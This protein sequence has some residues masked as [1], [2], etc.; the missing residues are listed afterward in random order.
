MKREAV[1]D[2]SLEKTLLSLHAAMDVGSFWKAIQQLLSAAIPNRLIGL[3]LQPNPILPMIA[4]WTLPVPDG[5]FAADP[6][7]SY[8]SAR[9]HHRF[10]RI[11]N[12]FSNRR[13]LMKSAFYR[14]YMAPQRCAHGLCL[15]FWKRQRLICAIAIM[16]TATQDDLSRAE[17][18]LLQQLYPQFQTAL[19]RL[20][21]LERE[22]SVR[23]DLEEF[24]SR[25]PMPTIILRWNLKPIYQNRA[26]REF[27]AIWEKGPEEAKR[28]K[29]AS[30]IPSE[31]LD[32]CRVFKQH[33]AD[34][35]RPNP[36]RA[37]FKEEQVRHPR[38]THLRATVHLKQLKSAGVAR[39]HFVIECEDS[40]HNG[41]GHARL[42]N[43][44]LP[45]LVRLTRR[46]QEVAQLAC[47]GRSNKEI[48]HD[49][50]LSLQMVKK[51]LH[52]VFRKLEVPSRSRLV[53]LM[54]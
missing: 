33:W 24:L 44:H 15:F 25:L 19:C 16:R 36:P 38:L 53:A 22:H 41:G 4:R 12:L 46:E 18:K 52:A 1:I 21:S 34:A 7:K 45:A 28:T 20:G 6:L 51:H 11:S 32:R 30:P 5:F 10:V 27:C 50:C 31:I 48:A 43:S 54:V 23:M 17:M 29:A 14:R 47:E 39:P 9:P 26:A 42:V 49:A 2:P 8:I 37:G 35:K 40:C 13:S 3:M